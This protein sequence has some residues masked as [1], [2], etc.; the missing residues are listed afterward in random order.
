MFKIY[1]SSC[2]YC[3]LFDLTPF[4]SKN[5]LSAQ[6]NYQ[7]GFDMT[8]K[9]V[10][11]Q[12]MKDFNEANWESW[13]TNVA[14]D[15]TMEDM[16]SGDKKQGIDQ[17][18]EYVTGWKSTFSDITGVVTNR[19]ESGDTLIEECTWTGTNDGEIPMPD[20]SKIPATGK[21][22]TI[23]NVMIWGY[24]DGKLS[25]F[26]NYRDAMSMGAQLGLMG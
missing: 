3:S 1:N 13:K 8:N 2:C 25:S 14:P 5:L 26:K 18:M 9:E 12:L 17:V 23:K 6:T 7:T 10:S 4:T 16:A 22:V 24:K 19:I 20:G 21:S 15:V 11:E